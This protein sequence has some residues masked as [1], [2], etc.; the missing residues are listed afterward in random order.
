[1]W[2]NRGL[3]DNYYNKLLCTDM[4]FHD[5]DVNVP[6]IYEL[7]YE[8]ISSYWLKYEVI[9]KLYVIQQGNMCST[10]TILRNEVNVN[11]MMFVRFR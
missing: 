6:V 8:K 11:F 1:M 7:T 9:M 3:F 2:H 10:Q 4:N 5:D